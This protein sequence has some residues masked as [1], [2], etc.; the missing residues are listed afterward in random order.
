MRNEHLFY[1]ITLTFHKPVNESKSLYHYSSSTHLLS[2]ELPVPADHGS[3]AET[4]WVHIGED[5]HRQEARQ[6]TSKVKMFEWHSLI[7]PLLDKVKLPPMTVAEKQVQKPLTLG[8]CPQV[9]LEK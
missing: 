9:K 8:V 2:E 4:P 7:K 1:N 5:F 6:D 3:P